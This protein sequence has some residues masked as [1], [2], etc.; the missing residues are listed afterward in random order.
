LNTLIAFTCNYSFNAHRIRI[1]CERSIRRRRNNVA[2]IYNMHAVNLYFSPQKRLKH[3]R[4]SIA[5]HWINGIIRNNKCI[6]YQIKCC[7]YTQNGCM[8]KTILQRLNPSQ[9]PDRFSKLL[10]SLLFSFFVSLDVRF[11]TFDVCRVNF[12]YGVSHEGKYCTKF[13]NQ[14]SFICSKFYKHKQ[15]IEPWKLST[16]WGHTKVLFTC[17]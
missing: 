2:E 16:S 15:N 13:L 11:R 14:Y 6:F 12:M 9:I 10:C 4:Q 8:N 17:C 1:T 3:G 5:L 7:F